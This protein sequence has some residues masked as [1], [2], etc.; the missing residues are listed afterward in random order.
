MVLLRW[1]CYWRCWS[2]AVRL[3]IRL[4]QKKIDRRPIPGNQ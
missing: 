1:Y 3:N 2:V 4:R